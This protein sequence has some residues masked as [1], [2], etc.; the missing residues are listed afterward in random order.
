MNKTIQT[1]G[2]LLQNIILVMV[3]ARSAIFFALIEFFARH[4]R[5]TPPLGCVRRARR[6]FPWLH[7]NTFCARAARAPQIFFGL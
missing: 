5:A 1:R 2:R 4:T 6:T 3:G 7:R